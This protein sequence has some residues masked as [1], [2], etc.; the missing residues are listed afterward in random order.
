MP[1]KA[2]PCVSA[3]YLPGTA[4]HCA[5]AYSH[6][7]YYT[8]TTPTRKHFTSV[9]FSYFK[10][11]QNIQSAAPYFRKDI[12]KT[13]ENTVQCNQNDTKITLQTIRGMTDR[14]K[15]ISPNKTKAKRGLDCSFQNLRRLYS[16]NVNP[17]VYF[18]VDRTN[19][20]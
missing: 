5:P 6:P 10:C 15:F 18:I 20:M 1:S 2:Y 12:E 11:D 8:C 14:T 3:V 7:C 19:I 16:T 9:V 13:R 17:D 4:Y